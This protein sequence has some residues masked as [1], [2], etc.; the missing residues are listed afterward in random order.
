MTRMTHRRLVP[1]LL[2]MLLVSVPRGASAQSVELSPFAGYRFGGDLYEE[3]AGKAL[4]VDG[5]PS[6]GAIVDVSIAPGTA[7]SFVYSHQE[8]RVDLADL[9]D[10]A[11]RPVRLSID[12]WLAGGTQEM[13]AT[14]RVRPFLTGDLGLTRFGSADDYEVRFTVA[15]GGGVKLMP[16]RHVGLRLDGRVYA[17]FVNGGTNGGICAPRGCVIGLDV[18]TLWQAEFTAGLVVAF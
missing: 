5:A 7:V 11:P 6:V 8:T 12:H 18:A 14:R 1:W 4:D 10:P 3:I 16:S 13:G 15:G 17:V 9:H 2:L